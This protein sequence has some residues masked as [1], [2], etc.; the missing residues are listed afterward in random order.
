MMFWMHM[1]RGWL[2][3]LVPCV[4]AFIISA[5][6]PWDAFDQVIGSDYW[7]AF[8]CLFGAFWIA[9]FFIQRRKNST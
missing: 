8:V 2:I 3:L 9:L 4:G 7:A 5:F 1:F 6:T